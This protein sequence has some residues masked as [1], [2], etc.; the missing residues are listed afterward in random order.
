VIVTKD[1]VQALVIDVLSDMI[2]PVDEKTLDRHL[3]HDLKID[4]DDLSFLF[5]DRLQKILKVRVPT[6]EWA[7]VATARDAIELLAK[8]VARD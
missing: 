5:A 6:E 4:S 2:G 7:Q 3:V 8:T 1:D